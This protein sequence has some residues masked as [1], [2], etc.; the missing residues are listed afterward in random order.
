MNA[1]IRAFINDAIAEGAVDETVEALEAALKLLK[2]EKEAQAKKTNNRAQLLHDLEQTVKTV[3]SMGVENIV[4]ADVAAFA[5]LGVAADH[6][7]WGADKLNVYFNAV[8]RGIESAN[9]T[10]KAA[11]AAPK[12]ERKDTTKP[13][14]LTHIPPDATIIHA[15]SFE[16]AMNQIKNILH[17]NCGDGV[18]NCAKRT[19]DR[20]KEKMPEPAEIDAIVKNF[21]EKLT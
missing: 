10:T 6:P 5:T 20:I 15:S 8:R 3:W 18:C 13:P 9:Q 14:K 2:E 11:F 17:E 4:P 7:D 21:L 1:D 12:Q 19:A 16:D